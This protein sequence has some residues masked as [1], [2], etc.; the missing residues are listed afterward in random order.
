VVILILITFNNAKDNNKTNN[1]TEVRENSELPN[2]KQASGS[3]FI[4][5]IRDAATETPVTSSFP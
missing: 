3:S 4:L 1:I 2:F 5:F